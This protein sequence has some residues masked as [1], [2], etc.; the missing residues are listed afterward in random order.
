MID[1]LS[2][3]VL[4]ENWSIKAV[5]ETVLSHF[6]RNVNYLVWSDPSRAYEPEAH[7]TAQF[8]VTE[9]RYYDPLRLPNA[10]LRFVR[11]SLSAPDTFPLRARPHPDL[12]SEA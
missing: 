5:L 3:A 8:Y 9:H 7:L 11:F 12:L 10:Y 2:R 6:I 4:E 1:S